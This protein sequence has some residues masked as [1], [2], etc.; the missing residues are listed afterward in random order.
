MAQPANGGQNSCVAAELEA[1]AHATLSELEAA[2]AA[3][4]PVAPA[5]SVYVARQQERMAAAA[6]QRFLP[7]A[8]PGRLFDRAAALMAPAAP[9][10][11]AAWA[12]CVLTVVLKDAPPRI[13]QAARRADALLPVLVRDCARKGPTFSP[14]ALA[15]LLE[16]GSA[17]G[18]AEVAAKAR[19]AGAVD[20]LLRR[21][22]ATTPGVNDAAGGDCTQRAFNA[23]KWIFKLTVKTG[24]DLRAFL[25]TPGLLSVVTRWLKRAGNPPA[26]RAAALGL[27]AALLLQQAHCDDKAL[28]DA[29]LDHPG[30]LEG[31]AEA[32]ADAGAADP[33][34]VSEAASV[35]A[36]VAPRRAAA[37][38]AVP[39]FF[40]GFAAL[41]SRHHAPPGARGGAQE[42]L[43][44]VASLVWITTFSAISKLL[45][46]VLVAFTQHPTAAFLDAC[47]RLAG[48]LEARVAQAEE[49]RAAAA[50]AGGTVAQWLTG[51]DFASAIGALKSLRELMRTIKKA[52]D[53]GGDAAGICQTLASALAAEGLHGVTGGLPGGGLGGGGSGGSDSGARGDD[54]APV[55]DTAR[56]SACRGRNGVGASSSSGS[57]RAPRAAAAPAVVAPAAAAAAPGKEGRCCFACGRAESTGG[58]SGAPLLQCGSC[59]GTGLK[60]FFC[61]K[62]CLKAGWK[63]HK[64]ACEAARRRRQDS[65]GGGNGAS[66]AVMA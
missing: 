10:K 66:G 9:R 54:V 17:A 44:P 30:L 49:W 7:L 34:T 63:A 19:R 65:G 21:A 31:A 42:A 61:D 28:L 41:L 48:A 2:A 55:R 50:R 36:V 20:A 64:P 12:C 56:S 38:A 35:L 51:G 14:M 29:V 8:D 27:L 4:G 26:P 24:G 57:D 59:K 25:E 47:P 53:A 40:D 23:L 15:C 13:A 6:A 33:G 1:L 5:L 52:R 18:D 22:A 11:V 46:S 37:L 62:A 16:E 58:S 3:A 32:V 39:G 45:V 60:A 43:L